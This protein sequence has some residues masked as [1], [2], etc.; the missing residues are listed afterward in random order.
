M[1]DNGSLQDQAETCAAQSR[2]FDSV[3]RAEEA[4]DALHKA[5]LLFA[6]ADTARENTD[7]PGPLTRPRADACRLYGD[8]L[9]ALGRHADAANIY[10]EATDLYGLIGDSDARKSAGDC[11]RR[12]LQSV[13]ALRADPR[14][15]LHLLVAHYERSQEQLAL[16]PGMEFR[17]AECRMHIARIYQRRDRPA[18]SVECYR[19]SLDLL[20]ACDDLSETDLTRAECHH[21]IATLLAEPLGQ[22][23][24]AVSHY[25][26]AIA[27]YQPHE[28]FV[29]GFQQSLEL[30]RS[31]LER[32][33]AAESKQ[34]HG[35]DR[36]R[37]RE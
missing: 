11:A 30:C 14:G 5:V 18:D 22:P 1:P 16:E 20:A 4:L 3:G 24:E 9:A 28:P 27:L 31:G 33:R 26:R 17:Q 2:A 10:Q 19:E 8:S 35:R 12:L 36:E 34:D 13:A 15:R 29:H 37:S 6:A 25:Q 7:E 21:R 32:A 23:H